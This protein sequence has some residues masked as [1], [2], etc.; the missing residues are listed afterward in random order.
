[1]LSGNSGV[2]LNDKTVVFSFTKSGMLSP[3]LPIMDHE[4]EGDVDLFGSLVC[5][6]PAGHVY[7]ESA[8]DSLVPAPS[9]R[10]EASE[11]YWYKKLEQLVH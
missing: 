10:F 8:L 2:F 5:L 11:S 7:S 3:L 6:A 9:S 4:V 1:M